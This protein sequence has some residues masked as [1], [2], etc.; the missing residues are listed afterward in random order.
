MAG[1]RKNR[2]PRGFWPA[3]GLDHSAGRLI[4]LAISVGKPS[5][6]TKK[7][8]LRM[9]WMAKPKTPRVD[10][11][12]FLLACA[13]ARPAYSHTKPPPSMAA[14]AKT[15]STRPRASRLSSKASWWPPAWAEPD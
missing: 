14:G 11:E 4:S 3:E 6:E 2:G 10:F 15:T 8:L 9:Q 13:A 1:R 5:Y 7:A 12:L